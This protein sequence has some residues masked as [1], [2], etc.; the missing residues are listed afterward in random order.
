MRCLAL[1][2]VFAENNI[3]FEYRENGEYTFYEIGKPE[4]FTTHPLSEY[5]KAMMKK[6][7]EKYFKAIPMPS[8]EENI[9]D[10]CLQLKNEL[11]ELK[12]ATAAGDIA[13]DAADKKIREIEDV[14]KMLEA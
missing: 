1:E 8:P 6:K 9:T 5:D 7:R 12:M 4:P 11:N 14:L 3:W 2:T 10:I 13:P